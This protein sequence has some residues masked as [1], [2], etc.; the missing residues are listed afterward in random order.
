MDAAGSTPA[1]TSRVSCYAFARLF[2][3]ALRNSVVPLLCFTGVA[4]QALE[5]KQKEVV[6]ESPAGARAADAVFTFENKGKEPVTIIT[7]TSSCP[8][9][10]ATADKMTYEAGESGKITAHFDFEGRTGK[11]ERT[12]LVLAWEKG[13]QTVTKLTLKVTIGAPV[14]HAK[15]TAQDENRQPYQ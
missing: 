12:F 14:E 15:P 1:W 4:L 13:E 7:I 3:R 11:Q 5:W 8:C 10:T 2:A 9:T 6:I